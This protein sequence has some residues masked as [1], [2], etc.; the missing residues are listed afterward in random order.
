MYHEP[1]PEGALLDEPVR[2]CVKTDL[3]PDGS[4]GSEWLV[5]TESKLCVFAESDGTSRVR[6]ESALADL[7]EL[8]AETFVGGG[9]L[10]ALR[11]GAREEV[12]R[13]TNARASQFATV[14]QLIGKW[15]EGEDAEV[16]EEEQDSCP[17]CGLPLEK[18][19]RICPLCVP[20]SRALWR[21]VGY[22]KP[23]WPAAAGL[24]LFA[25]L[26]TALGLV[27]PYL[28]KPLMDSVLA[29]KDATLSVG[30]RLRWLGMLVLALA[31]AQTLVAVVTTAQSWLSAW[32][33]TRITHDIRC[34]LFRHLQFLSLNFFDKRQ[35]GNVISRVNQDASQLERFLVWGSQDLIINF[36]LIVGIGL[37]LFV[38]NWKLA[39][40]VFVPAPLIGL[41]SAAF[42]KRIRYYIHRYFHRWS[43]LNAILS[44]A[45]S[46]LKVVKAFGQ[47]R[48]EIERFEDQSAEVAEAGV[49]GERVWA[50]VFSIVSLIVMLGTLI[51]VYVG[52][53]D[54]LRGEMTVGTLVAFLA[55]LAMFFGPI[56]SLSMLLNWSSRS[57]TAAERVFEVLDSQ[58]EIQESAEAVPMPEMEGRVEFRQVQ[59]GYEKHR[60]VLKSVSFDV[61]PGEMIG[62]VGHSGAGKTTAINL[63]CRFYDASDGEILIDGVPI[64]QIRIEDLRRQ[65]GLVP[66]DT[67][68]FKGTIADNISYG[69]PD[70]TREE[71]LRASKIANAHEFVLKKSDGY[72]TVIGEKGQ[73]L[74]GG[75]KQRIAIARAVLHDPRILILDEATSH[76]DLETEKQIQEAIKRLVKGRT[77]FAIAHRLSTLKH[78]NRLVVLKSGEVT[79]I[80]SH[81]ELMEKKGEFQKLV[82][83]YQEISQVREVAR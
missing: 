50:V 38:M 61:S 79:E 72:E 11:D 57:L 68:L 42:W 58:P 69:K 76:V 19:S 29:P 36:L 26:S 78:S 63:L 32:L 5:V 21:L 14:A 34:R 75:E 4:I 1:L 48:R 20:K 52:G 74:S 83:T 77:T 10:E 35:L 55:Y 37:M 22:L 13:Y 18:G 66:Q 6:W 40:C 82:E 7:G 47:E 16:P 60:P 3:L 2:I 71:V 59:F 51:V 81:D 73:G 23:H 62:L 8:K 65:I 44:E 33:G 64:R 45:L 28:Q 39:L 43:R 54:V 70:A 31:A 15:S 12:V 25:F 56:R 41:T 80:G 46:G 53:R 67:F 24:S 49:K 30:V 9:A 27:P 17:K